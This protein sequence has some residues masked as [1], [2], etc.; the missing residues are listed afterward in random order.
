MGDQVRA[1]LWMCG[2]ITAMLTMA[3]AGRELTDAD[4]SVFQIMVIRAGMG[5]MVTLPIIFFLGGKPA[6]TG[7]L[8]LH[9]LRNSI[10]F[11]AQYAWFV[12]ISL[13]PLAQVVTIEFTMPI[14]TAIFAAM[15]IGEQITRNR[16]L[17][18]I[19]GFIGVLVILRPGVEAIHWGAIVVM[20]AAAGFGAS[21]T[22][23][24]ELAKADSALTIVFYMFLVQFII[25]IGPA[26]YQWVHITSDMLP[27]ALLVAATGGSS[28]FFLA[29]A[30]R[31][32]DATFV[33]TLDFLRVPLMAIIAWLLYS[34]PLEVWLF[35]G[36]VIILVANLIN[37][38]K[39]ARVSAVE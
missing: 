5:L 8:K 29:K 19:L 26:L 16:V 14:W 35:A 18:I 39:P 13:I 4:M 28:H 27:W 31:T 2:W 32:A 1:T 17:A 24:R 7:L 30:M 33:V 21:V 23:T 9:V 34:E 22:M 38:K 37:L 10:H 20:Y 25:G 3:V 15:F 12:G 11:T 6:Q 36:G